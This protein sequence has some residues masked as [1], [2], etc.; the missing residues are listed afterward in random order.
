LVVHQGLDDILSKRRLYAS[1]YVTVDLSVL[2][3]VN[4][5]V[6]DWT[7]RAAIFEDICHRILQTQTICTDEHEL[8]AQRWLVICGFLYS[9]FKL[10]RH[11]AADSMTIV[12]GITRARSRQLHD[13]TL[14]EVRRQLL[15]VMDIPEVEVSDLRGTRAIALAKYA[16]LLVPADFSR[17]VYLMRNLAP[18]IIE[19]GRIDWILDGYPNARLLFA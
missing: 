10:R 9:E 13:L 19:Q 18:I 6:C 11:E 4:H 8:A 7:S 15:D 17:L 2:D 14:L 5:S 3:H 1:R 16:A 12:Y